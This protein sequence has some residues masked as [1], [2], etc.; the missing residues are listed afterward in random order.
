MGEVRN[1][2]GKP[3]LLGGKT[4]KTSSSGREGGSKGKGDHPGGGKKKNLTIKVR[5]TWDGTAPYGRGKS[6][7]S[8][9][10]YSVKEM[11][12]EGAGDT[13][14]TRTRGIGEGGLKT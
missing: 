12:I 1:A 14:R 5:S 4:K 8:R 2:G 9:V 10:V 13:E 6:R 7:S 11:V 3:C